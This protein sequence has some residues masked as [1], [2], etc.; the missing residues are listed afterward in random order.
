MILIRLKTT[1]IIFI[2]KDRVRELTSTHDSASHL[3]LRSEWPRW[4]NDYQIHSL[5]AYLMSNMVPTFIF[6][7]F[8]ANNF[9]LNISSIYLWWN[10]N[11]S[12][13]LYVVHNGFKEIFLL[14]KKSKVWSFYLNF[15]DE[16]CI[17]YRFV[18]ISQRWKGYLRLNHTSRSF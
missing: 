15:F 13:Y 14:I 9:L 18:I 12:G 8:L 4:P 7:D 3:L 16:F 6:I 11:D 10:I 2:I 17:L 1:K 5:N